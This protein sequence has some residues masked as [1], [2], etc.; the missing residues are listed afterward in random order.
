MSAYNRWALI[1]INTNFDSLVGDQSCGNQINLSQEAPMRKFVTIVVGGALAMNN[2][3]KI[4]AGVFFRAALTVS[5]GIALMGLGAR[6]ASAS[7]V[8]ISGTSLSGLDYRDNGGTAAYVAGTPDVA[9][10]STSDSGSGP[11]GGAPVVFVNASNAGLAS[12]GTLGSFSASYDLFGS[13]SGPAAPY[14]LTYLNDPNGGKVGVISFGGPD[15]NG[16]SQIHVFCAF[17]T[18]GSCTNDYWGDTLATLD[19]IAYGSTTFGL[20]TVFS[21]GVEI[22]DWN[23]NGQ[24]IPAQADIQSITINTATT[25]LPAALPL[26][27]S[28]LG[29]LGLLGWRRKRKAAALAA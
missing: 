15:L 1:Q 12:L 10:L 29:A 13:A 8:T 14:W 16:S 17:S 4:I 25:P 7:V 23:N 26:F 6:S 20:L 18:S 28:G 19:S 9:R 21:S 3:A 24:T 22:G 27:A 2:K 5:F 11:T